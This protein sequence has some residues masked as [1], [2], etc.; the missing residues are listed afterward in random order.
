M[1]YCKGEVKG[2]ASRLLPILE[3]V[4]EA[5]DSDELNTKLH[6]LLVRTMIAMFTNQETNPNHAQLVFNTH[7]TWQLSNNSLRRDEIW[8]TDKNTDGESSLYSLAEFCSDQGPKIRKDEQY[9]KNYLLG[10]Y[11]AI[12]SL[13]T[14]RLIFPGFEAAEKKA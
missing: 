2:L 4:K 9:E 10:K 14:M 7:D 3:W 1:G 13:K 11:R 6:P 5:I 8:F 12:P